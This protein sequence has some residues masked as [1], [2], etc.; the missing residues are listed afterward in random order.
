MHLVYRRGHPAES[1]I[2]HHQV[3][4]MKRKCFLVFTLIIAICQLAYSQQWPKVYSNAYA[5]WLIESYDRGYF[6]TGPN[7]DYDYSLIIKT[8]INGDALW[9]LSVGNGQ[10]Q[11]SFFSI[12]QSFD[13]GFVVTGQSNK[14]DSWG[15]PV[16]MKFSAC[17]EVEWCTVI[18]TPGDG[19]RG[20]QVRS[21]PDSCYLILAMYSDPN[22]KYRIQ[23]FKFDRNG[24]LIW[25]Q[26]Y[27]P[28]SLVFAENS[29]NL[30]VDSTYYLISAKCHYPDPGQ[31]GGY[32]RPYYIKT[33]T[34]GNVIW[35]LVYGSGNGF[36]GFPFY[37]PV[38]SSSG[39][40]YDVGWHSNYCDT[41]ALWK[42]TEEGTEDYFQDLFPGSCPAGSSALNFLNDTTLVTMVGGTISGSDVYKWIKT[43]TLGIEFQEKE[44]TE[45]WIKYTGL[46]IISSDRKITSISRSLGGPIYYF[47]KLNSDLEFDSIYTVP[48]TYDSLCPYPIVS[49]TVDPDC[50]LIVS[51]KDPEEYPE[52]YRLRVYPNPASNKV[53]V[54]IPEF[55]IKRSGTLVGAGSKPAPDG[56]GFQVTTVY[57]QWGSALLEVYDL[58]GRKM[59]EQLVL[60]AD[61][62]VEVDVSQWQGGMY[63]F[64]LSYRGETIATEK[65][66]VE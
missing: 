33:D 65:V 35:K 58:F 39:F 48:R 24:E 47:Y 28:D 20:R 13:G 32:E 63:V 8:T 43:D 34:A 66:V 38:K 50:G 23:L 56:S 52:L 5:S 21:T 53:T 62:E 41:P 51:I 45:N 2:Y 57:H 46:S 19:D 55:L 31:T 15:D 27:P 22:P 12:D 25:R 17:G 6:I 9:T 54:E 42:F 64:R 3:I 60:Q 10:Y 4:L 49:D 40:F 37:K 61:R 18:N 30:F 44:Y 26:N 29:K 36:H 14:Y 7:G 1:E 16:I 11:S 59:M